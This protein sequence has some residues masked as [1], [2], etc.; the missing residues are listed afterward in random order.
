MF[1]LNFIL[2]KRQLC[3]SSS[4]FCYYSAKLNAA[5]AFQICLISFVPSFERNSMYICA[6]WFLFRCTT[7][8]VAVHTHQNWWN[9]HGKEKRAH[10]NVE[11][12]AAEI[13]E[14]NNMIVKILENINF[15]I[16]QTCDCIARLFL[17]YISLSHSLLFWWVQQTYF[18]FPHSRITWLPFVLNLVRFSIQI[19]NAR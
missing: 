6:F 17:H 5:F 8:S 9:S 19:Q 3:L 7:E 11:K 16:V 1:F 12:T 14:P 10:I 4:L 15:N 18:T 2:N 13:T